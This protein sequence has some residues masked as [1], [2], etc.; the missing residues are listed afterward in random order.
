MANLI[1]DFNPGYEYNKSLK[2]LAKSLFRELKQNGYERRHIVSLSS[3][4]LSL[5]TSE[6]KDTR[7]VDD[8]M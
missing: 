5:V 2:I 3:E 4:L 6:I 8:S 7:L 1:T